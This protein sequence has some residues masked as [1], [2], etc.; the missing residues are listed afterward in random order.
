MRAESLSQPRQ[1]GNQFSAQLSQGKSNGREPRLTMKDS[2]TKEE[3]MQG[4]FLKLATESN[5]TNRVWFLT[6][7][8]LVCDVIRVK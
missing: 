6:K 4:C 3:P 1:Q 5:E 8:V 2:V 7:S